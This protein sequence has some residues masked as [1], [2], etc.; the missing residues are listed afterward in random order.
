MYEKSFF[1]FWVT[2]ILYLITLG[3]VTYVGVYLTYIAIPMIVISGLVMLLSKPKPETQKVL[4]SVSS[5]TKE[6]RQATNEILND[7]RT[8]LA[9]F[10]EKHKVIHEHTKELRERKHQLS[11]AKIKPEVALQ[12]EQDVMRRK[13]L[14]STISN[15]DRDIREID[16]SISQIERE[17]EKQIERKYKK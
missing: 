10:N 8:S 7:T 2:L 1:V 16:S 3:T 4:D 17:C 14:A 9:Q 11:L 12:S 6:A 15:I 13:E 5:L